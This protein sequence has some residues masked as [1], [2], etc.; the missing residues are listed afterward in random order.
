MIMEREEG[1]RCPFSISLD[2]L[3]VRLKGCNLSGILTEY[4]FGVEQ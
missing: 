1:T 4:L 2:K 3:V